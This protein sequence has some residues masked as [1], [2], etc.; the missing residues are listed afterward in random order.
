M[1]PIKSSPSWCKWKCCNWL[2]SFAIVDLIH[3]FCRSTKSTAAV[4]TVYID[5]SEQRL[6]VTITLSTV[7]TSL[8]MLSRPWTNSFLFIS[9]HGSQHPSDTQCGYLTWVRWLCSASHNGITDCKPY[10]NVILSTLKQL[11][12][13][14]QIVCDLSLPPVRVWNC[15]PQ[16]VVQDRIHVWQAGKGSE[17]LCSNN[18][19]WFSRPTAI[20][21]LS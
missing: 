10:P 14:T 20:A 17:L 8:P 1:S 7:C 9:P 11:H 15:C 13:C 21:I 5:N 12:Y 3:L 4:S 6:S 16:V 19:W 2:H 18:K